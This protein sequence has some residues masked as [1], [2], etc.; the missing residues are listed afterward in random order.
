MGAKLI[1]ANIRTD[2]K[3]RTDAFR[4]YATAPIL[5]IRLATDTLRYPS[6]ATD[7]SRIVH[8]KN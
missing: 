8:S 5:V 3:K 7:M 1:H 4:D 6:K 2:V